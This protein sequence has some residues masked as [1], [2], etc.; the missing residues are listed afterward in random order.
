MALFELGSGP[1][2]DSCRSL[3]VKEMALFKKIFMGPA[4][5]L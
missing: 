1:P 4:P 2:A 5:N 3:A